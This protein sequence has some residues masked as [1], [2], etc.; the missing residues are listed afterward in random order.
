MCMCV[1]LSLCVCMCVYVL[2]LLSLC[3]C[4]LVS[5]CVCVCLLLSYSLLL[6]LALTLSFSLPL[7][8][9]SRTYVR[10]CQRDY[11]NSGVLFEMCGCAVP[12][13][14][15]T[16]LH[17]LRG[18]RSR[19]SS[20]FY[21]WTFLLLSYTH[22]PLFSFS[23]SYFFLFSTELERT[24]Q[25]RKLPKRSLPRRV[26]FFLAISPNVCLSIPL[27]LHHHCHLLEYQHHLS[28]VEDNQ[29]VPGLSSLPPSVCHS[30]QLLHTRC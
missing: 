11:S 24:L 14:S 22:I 1:C 21:F 16:A 13:I 25:R 30:H 15:T 20:S 5:L 12:A 28:K 19:T 10:L 2:V 9:S 4:L 23:P 6:S 3:A 17:A 29:K 8:S 27:Q 18:H 7:P 26:L